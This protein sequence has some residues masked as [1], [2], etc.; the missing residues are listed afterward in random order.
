MLRIDTPALLLD[1]ERLERNLAAMAARATAAGLA[2][3]PHFKTARMVPVAERLARHGARRFTVSTLAEA[4]A[5]AAAG[6]GDDV[7]WAVGLAPQRAARVVALR[8][9]GVGLAVTIDNLPA[10]LAVQSAVRASS[11]RP[12]PVWIELDC[13]YGRAGLRPDDPALAVLAA[14]VHAAEEAT[15]VGLLTHAGHAYGARGTDAVA[16]C[17]RQ[18]RDALLAGAAALEAAGLPRPR[19]S[20]G[21]TPTALVGPD[22]AGGGWDGIDELRP[23]NYVFLDVAQH[24][25]GVCEPEAIATSVLATVIGHKPDAALP[26]ICIDA[27]SM[28]LSPDP[29]ARDR[30]GPD[31]VD[32]GFGLVCDVDGAVWPGLRVGSVSQEHGWIVA[33]EGTALP[34]DALPVGARVRILPAHACLTAAMHRGAHLVRGAYVVDFWPRV[35]GW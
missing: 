28:A 31:D 32:H 19:L 26:H 5:L 27:G 20:A 10:L 22:G 12:V 25:I 21:S 8:R 6:L 4:A 16:A 35:Q 2:L 29:S 17:A 33:E 7:L 11:S 14:A 30:A 24:R 3:R 15:L 9:R 23:G 1:A 13:G 18:E 34:L